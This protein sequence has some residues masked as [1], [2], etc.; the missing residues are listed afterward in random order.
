MMPSA[1]TCTTTF[2]FTYMRRKC[3]QFL[4]FL[5]S[6][7]PLFLFRNVARNKRF[8]QGGHGQW[9]LFCITDAFEVGC[10]VSL[11]VNL[12]TCIHFSPLLFLTLCTL[13][14]GFYGRRVTSLISSSAGTVSTVKADVLLEKM[15][16]FQGLPEVAL[17][18]P[19]TGYTEPSDHVVAAPH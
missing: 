11:R 7:L 2:L 10:S 12:A 5:S 17:W 14:C 3:L 18:T 9:P 15:L 4:S 6:L 16:H 1:D 13:K 19:E 8:I